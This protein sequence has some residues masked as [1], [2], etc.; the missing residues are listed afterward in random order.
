MAIESEA[1]VDHRH[2]RLQ[3]MVAGSAKNCAIVVI[4]VRTML[5]SSNDFTTGGLL[6]L[7]ERATIVGRPAYSHREAIDASAGGAGGSASLG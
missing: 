6:D 1:G 7:T 2:P 3:M 4:D 5:L